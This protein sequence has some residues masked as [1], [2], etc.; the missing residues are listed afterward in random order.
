MSSVLKMSKKIQNISTDNRCFI[1]CVVSTAGN[2]SNF[3]A[4]KRSGYQVYNRVIDYNEKFRQISLRVLT[5]LYSKSEKYLNDVNKGLVP[6]EQPFCIF[7]NL[8]CLAQEW[9]PGKMCN[10]ANRFLVG[11]GNLLYE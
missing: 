2:G 8:G 4:L 5:S 7:I 9:F 1:E 10:E 6:S 11:R 3:V